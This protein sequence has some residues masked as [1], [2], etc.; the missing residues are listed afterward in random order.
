M[1]SDGGARLA[2]S[3]PRYEGPLDLLLDLVRRNPYPIDA[4]PVSSI[5]G[6]FLAYVRTAGE[7]DP[8]LAGEFVEAASWLVLLQ[9]RS[10]LPHG[11]GDGTA[12]H[13]ELRRAVV[14]HETLLAATEFLQIR[15]GR[16]RPGAARARLGHGEEIGEDEPDQAPTVLDLV[17]AA[18][19]ALEAAHAARSLEGVEAGG[20]TVEEMIGWIEVKLAMIPAGG[21]V[22]TREWFRVQPGAGAALLLGLLEMAA[23]GA[24]LL[25][26]GEDFGAIRAKAGRGNG[27]DPRSRAYEAAGMAAG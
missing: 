3:L 2:I 18:R 8:D 16:A 17:E 22:S 6:Q 10:M 27:Q 11:S 23:K 20:V 14:D 7:L 24:L 19:K 15:Q 1:A 26:Q 5:T 21:A 13:E 12:P 4:L 25:H 9:S